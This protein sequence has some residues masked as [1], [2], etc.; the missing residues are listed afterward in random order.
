MAGSTGMN[1]MNET[2][3]P[4]DIDGVDG[5]EFHERI[6]RAPGRSTAMRAGIVAGSALLFVVGAV[7]AMGASPA[8]STGAAPAAS[9]DPGTNTDPGASAAPRA[10]GAPDGKQPAGDRRG[11]PGFGPGGFG[12]GGFGPAF[13]PGGFGQV[14]F[15][16]I[17]ISAIDGSNISLKTDD[18]WTRTVAVTSATT[19]TKGG[20]TIAIGD[21]AVGDQVRFAQT[22][23]ADGSYSVTA[24]V[25]VLPTIAGEVTAI[26]GDTLTVTQPGGAT[27]MI[28]VG[29]STTYQV[30]GATGA[31]SDIKV[32]SF[33]VAE[34]TQRADGSLDAA[35][36]HSGT[37]GRGGLKGPGL[38]GDHGDPNGTKASPA[39]SR[40]TS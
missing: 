9:T 21:L 5:V 4:G 27:A 18:G 34:G 12:P 15:R 40:A 26:D 3:Q 13:G 29:G 33:I 22:R 8:P 32:G 2:H 39:P 24:I 31:L 25:V 20:A 36:V 10:S 28:H 6:Q 16:D 35:D 23:A 38:P 30:D 7:A 19:I 1:G 14:G 37:K 17:T 11:G